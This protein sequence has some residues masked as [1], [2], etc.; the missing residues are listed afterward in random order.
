MPLAPGV[1]LGSYEV[2]A[3]IGQGGM[4]EVWQGTVQVEVDRPNLMP[5]MPVSQRDSSAIS[6]GLVG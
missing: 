4:S 5:N 2:I 1:R 6:W 3:K